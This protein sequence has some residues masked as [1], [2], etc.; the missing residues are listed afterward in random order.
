M[1][2]T[3]NDMSEGARKLRSMLHSG[4][5]V[6]ELKAAAKPYKAYAGEVIRA[7]QSALD[8]LRAKIADDE[9]RLQ[10]LGDQKEVTE[11]ALAWM[12]SGPPYK[13]QP[14]DCSRAHKLIESMMSGP[15]YGISDDAR[16]LAARMFKDAT[17]FVVRHDWAAAFG[18][19]LD[20]AASDIKLPYEAC[21][22]EFTINGRCVIIAA[23]QAD[24]GGNAP[25]AIPFVE[26]MPGKWYHG[27]QGDCASEG[28]FA[29]AWRQVVAICV[30]LDSEVATHAVTRAPAALNKKREKAG[31]PPLKDYHVVDLSRRNRVIGFP[32]T[33]SHRSPRLH[34]RRGHWRHYED[35]KTWIKWTLVGSPDL[36]FVDK[37]YRM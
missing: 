18:D 32:A 35:H 16:M 10:W 30:A 24:Q 20:D 22:F 19:S 37:H 31:K 17:S 9:K 26:V 33:G 28:V 34:F 7:E 27:T 11:A 23:H 4:M 29:M 2:L 3:T 15:A 5:S 1:Y 13:L 12:Q 36:G 6:E 8:D 25:G 14:N 21:L